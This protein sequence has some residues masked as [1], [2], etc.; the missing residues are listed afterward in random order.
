MLFRSAY[1]A[2][3]N[4][5]P[6]GGSGDAS[7][8]AAGTFS[9][10]ASIANNVMTVTAVGSGSLYAGATVVGAASGTKIVQQ[11]TSTETDGALGKKGT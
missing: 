1:F 2:A 11:L 6:P 3:A 7:S 10:T 5:T 9:V 4:A 8:I